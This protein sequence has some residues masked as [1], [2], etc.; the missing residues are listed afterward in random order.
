MIKW[1]FILL[2]LTAIDMDCRAA[3]LSLVSVFQD[4]THQFTGVALSKTGRMFVN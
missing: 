4:N 2:L 3:D 1:T